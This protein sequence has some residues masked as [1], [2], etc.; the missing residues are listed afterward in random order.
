MELFSFAMTE[1]VK[2]NRMI[3]SAV[4]DAGASYIKGEIS[5][6]EA[7]EKAASQVN[8]YLSE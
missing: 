4:L 8:L 5:V 7:V 1:P 2:E 3:L 6:E